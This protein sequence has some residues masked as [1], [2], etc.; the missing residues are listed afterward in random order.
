LEVEKAMKRTTLSIILIVTFLCSTASATT[1]YTNETGW[2]RDGGAFNTTAT[3]LQ[4]AVDNATSGDSV[5]VWN[6]SY[7]ESAVDIATASITVEGES[8]TVTHINSNFGISNNYVTL[9]NFSCA[10]DLM[11]Q[12]DNAVITNTSFRSAWFYTVN[13]ATFSNTELTDETWLDFTTNSFFDN[14]EFFGVLMNHENTDN[15]F[16]YNTFNPSHLSNISLWSI[17]SLTMNNTF[18]NRW[19]EKQ[20]IH[21]HN[22]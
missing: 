5:Y 9:K 11:L 1:L 7:T 19:G 13:N 21:R 10:G 22:V 3:P 2:Y 16:T 18:S 14:N 4:H 15:T 12:G 17:S 8:K 20:H 6:G